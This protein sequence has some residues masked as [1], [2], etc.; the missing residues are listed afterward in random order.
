MTEAHRAQ[1]DRGEQIE[2]RLA[3]DHGREAPRHRQVVQ[4]RAAEGAEPVVADREPE[5]QGAEPAGE[6]QRFVEELWAAQDPIGKGR[7]TRT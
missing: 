7:P 5:S 6:F 4:D 3:L 2:R 1:F